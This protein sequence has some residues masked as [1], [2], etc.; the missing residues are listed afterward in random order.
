LLFAGQLESWLAEHIKGKFVASLP[1]TLIWQDVWLY[2]KDI[3]LQPR[4]A[5]EFFTTDSV[6]YFVPFDHITPS[7]VMQSASAIGSFKIVGVYSLTLISPLL[8]NDRIVDDD[9]VRKIAQQTEEIY[10][11][12]YDQESFVVWRRNSP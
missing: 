9:L 2:P 12:A 4:I 11:G 5:E 10:V 8:T 3:Q 7:Q 1:G 6:Y